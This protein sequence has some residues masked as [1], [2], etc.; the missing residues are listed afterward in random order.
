MKLESAP[1]DSVSQ[2]YGSPGRIQ[3]LANGDIVDCS[4]LPQTARNNLYKTELCKHFCETGSCRYNTK[5]QFAHG[6]EELR[7]VLRHPKYKTTRCKAFVSTGKC[8]Y[9]SRCRFIHSD[10]P[11][12]EMGD[13][14]SSTASESDDQDPMKDLSVYPFSHGRDPIDLLR[15]FSGGSKS[16]TFAP[17]SSTLTADANEYHFRGDQFRLDLSYGYGADSHETSST[18]SS[19]ADALDSLSP[20]SSDADAAAAK[21]SRLSIFQRICREQD[22]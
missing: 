12:D 17:L 16:M 1:I 6:E 19:L 3:I 4:A 10:L 20:R 18:T 21:F 22:E 5:C 11:E 15:P 14:V 8:V 2:S 7:G 13:S 9:G